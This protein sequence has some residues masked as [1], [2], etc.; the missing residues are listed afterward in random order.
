MEVSYKT[1]LFQKL[2]FKPDFNIVILNQPIGVLQGLD[3]RYKIEQK[4]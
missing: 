3:N 1:P 4:I 2:G